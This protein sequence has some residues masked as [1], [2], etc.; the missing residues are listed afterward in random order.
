MINVTLAPK[1]LSAYS[2]FVNKKV[3]SDIK[4]SAK[5]L[6]GKR[7]VEINSTAEGGG[8][9]EMLKSYIP[10]MQDCGLNV[11]WRVIMPDSQFFKVTKNIHNCLQ[12]TCELPEKAQLDYYHDYLQRQARHVPDA[13]LYILHDP[14][15]LGLIDHL[16][17]G[18]PI[19]WRCH[20]DLTNA[21]PT[22]LG[23]VKEYYKK[24]HKIIFSLD[25]YALG[26]DKS[27]VA[28]IPPAIDPLSDKNKPLSSKEADDLLED[29]NIDTE[30]PFVTQ[31][32]RFDKF[33]DPL[34]V[35]EMYAK[36]KRDTPELGCVLMGGYATDDPEGY[37]YFQ[38]VR[39]KIAE[40]KLGDIRV[41]TKEDGL[42]VNALQSQA[43]VVIQNSSREGFGLT[44]TEAL[45]KGAYVFARPVGGIALQVINRKTGFYILDDELDRDRISDVIKNPDKYKAIKKAAT[46]HVKDHFLVTRLLLDHLNLYRQ[47]TASV[48]K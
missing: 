16:P 13:D 9:A 30:K 45:W 17:P 20:I 14:Q 3:L 21:N 38:Q 34:G 32:S 23:W 1:R 5:A 29:F 22:T 31:I 6:K 39:R 4:T 40:L 28:L 10:L 25:N 2:K 11:S 18:K 35:L 44:V 19:I 46:K 33:K 37:P 8:V 7:I 36:L 43:A 12:G 15:T 41:I 24:L 26:V 27:K 42:L 47:A 48:E